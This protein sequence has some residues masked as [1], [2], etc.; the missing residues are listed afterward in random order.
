MNAWTITGNNIEDFKIQSY[1]FAAGKKKT[2]GAN[3]IL[4]RHTNRMK[5]KSG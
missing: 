5:M 3:I 4:K 2:D 1:R